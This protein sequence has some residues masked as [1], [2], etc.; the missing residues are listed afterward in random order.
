VLIVQ[1]VEKSVGEA[2]DL[3]SQMSVHHVDWKSKLRQARASLRTFVMDAALVAGYV[4]YCG[5]FDQRLRDRLLSDWLA[6]C[7]TGNF[8]FEMT[9]SDSSSHP[10]EHLLLSSENFSVEDV[11]GVAELLP[12]LELCGI[13]SDSGSRHNVALLYASVFGRSPQHRCTLLIDPDEQ[14]E[15]C[16]RYLLKRVPAFCNDGI[17]DLFL[18]IT[19]CLII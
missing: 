11:V 3:M 6:Y 14:A 10:K 13:L 4:T 7:E 15:S 2:D 18:Y 16:I 12:E 5:A 9:S 8:N 17:T 19:A 1:A